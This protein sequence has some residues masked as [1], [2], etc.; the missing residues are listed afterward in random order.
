MGALATVPGIVSLLAPGA[1]EAAIAKKFPAR[2]PAFRSRILDGII[3]DFALNLEYLEAEYYLQATTGAGLSA[4]DIT[5][6][7]TPGDVIVK[8]NPKVTFATPAIQDYA[9][10]IAEDEMNHVKFLR[11]AL[12][13]YN[14]P[15]AARPQI[16]LLNSFNALGQLI[17]LPSFD[18]FANEVNFLIGAF[19]FEDVGVTAYKGASP[20]VFDRGFLE[21]AAGILGVEAYHAGTVRTLLSAQGDGVRALVDKISDVR[22]S[23]DNL[24]QGV[25][26]DQGI[27]FNDERNI[28]P[29][30]NNSVAFSRTTRQVLNIV[31]G[32]V[33][34]TS[35]LFFPNGLNGTI[36]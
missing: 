23:L 22:A 34:A 29:T 16:D 7:G 28:V 10:E 4:Q 19:I 12:G 9:M 26:I 15:I 11:T 13:A 1:A 5:G 6:L 18:P 27:T 32:G 3:L 14:L 25:R 33:N 8:A 20:Q 35:G 24:P 36:R 17:G 2:A 21:A 30:D 31:Y